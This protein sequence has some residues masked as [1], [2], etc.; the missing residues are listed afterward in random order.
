MTVLRDYAA[1]VTQPPL[2]EDRPRRFDEVV[3]P[4][5]SLRPAW[6]PLA[7]LAVGLTPHDLYRVDG[8]IVRM[9]ADEGVTYA[10]PGERPGPWRLDPVPLVVDA[11]TWAPLEVGLA[12]RA[13]LLNALL[14]DLYG[15]QRVLTERVVPAAVVLGHPGFVRAMAGA[16][17]PDSHPLVFSAT[18]IG[19]DHD[20]TWR[21]VGDKTQA[22]SGIG[23]AMENRRV[24]SRVLPE[25]YREAGLH[26]M[27]PYFWA[28]RSALMQAAPGEVADPRVVVLTPGTH[29]ETAYDQAF[30]A[31]TLGFPLVEGSDLVVRDG[32]VY[33]RQNRGR[34][35]R[36]DVVVRRVD[37]SWSD[38]LELRG[39]SQLGVAGLTEA[40]RRGRVRIVNPIGAGVLESPALLP[41]LPA[42]CELLLGE[43]LLLPSVDSW[44]CGDPAGLEATLDLVERDPDVRVVA[45]DGPEDGLTG[46]PR[47][48]LVERVLARPHHYVGRR[49]PV[50]SQVPSWRAGAARPRPVTLRTFT[51]RYGTAYR[52]LV[53][54]MANVLD[55]IGTRSSSSKDVWVLKADPADADQ[56][57]SGVLAATPGR[58]APVAAP[59]VLEDLYWTGRY[60]E[61]AEG[62]LRLLLVTHGTAEDFRSRPRTAG[63]T[64]LE[65]LLGAQARLAGRRHENLDAEFRSLLLDEDRVGGV[66]HSVAALR[67]ALAGIRDQLS[68][69]TWRALGVIDRA[70]TLLEL[71][72]ASHQIAEAAGRHLTGLLSLQG[73][74][75]NMMQDDG[76]RLLSAGRWLERA[77]QLCHLLVATTTERRG[78]DVDRAVLAAVLDAAESGV[79]HRRRF[80]GYVRPAGVLDLLLLDP[81]NPRS[82]L[83]CLT[84]LRT[85]LGRLAG[86]TGSTRPERLLEHLLSEVEAQEV[87][88]LVAIGGTDRPLLTT[89]LEETLERLSTLGD[90]IAEHHLSSGPPP[91]P[92]NSLT[93]LDA[94]PAEPVTGTIPVITDDMERP[95]GIPPRVPRGGARREGDA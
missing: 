40:A 35:E 73:S 95:P 41:Y 94:L 59:R 66:G 37:A 1:A 27:E 63:G 43:S 71:S 83:H 68:V 22:P 9:L 24:L 64:S 32:W 92:L 45:V 33:L 56:G 18:D 34:M 20:G 38:P 5:G 12:Q 31:S 69:D 29:S 14:V 90:A 70:V 4:D 81:D 42:V 17:M 3:G 61:R 78:L 47:G 15:P 19:R 74:S 44:W 54:G 46:L 65:V 84:E 75:A 52:P 77:I 85:H 79:T 16:R 50:F 72:P 23:Y 28:L 21:A 39:E 87:S 36:V 7:E 51:V 8:D 67:D 93:V 11:G 53:G 13:E 26:R 49:D 58:A 82:L 86:S 76:W 30:L 91:R 57:L 25:M 80:R 10:R 48:E 6:K 55:D 62:M 60:A 88:S 2:D 89:F